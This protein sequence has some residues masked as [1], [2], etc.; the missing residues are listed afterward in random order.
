MKKLLTF[1]LCTLLLFACGGGDDG[2]GNAPSGGSEFLNV[3]NVDV[4][5]SE[6][7][8]KLSIQASA[9]CDWQVSSNDSWI[10]NIAPSSGRGSRDVSITLSG[11][12][13][14]SSSARKA[15][16]T[17]R[18]SSGT[19]TRTVTLTQAASK[20]YIEISGDATINFGNKADSRTIPIRSNT[21]WSVAVAVIT[22]SSDWIQVSPN[23]GSND[24]NVTLTVKDNNTLVEQKAKLT[25]MGTGGTT[26]E[27][28]VVQ[29]AASA[30]TLTRPQAS[31][32][33]TSEANVYFT[34]DSAIPVTSCGICYATTQ[35]TPD[36]KQD[37]LFAATATTSPVVVRMT[38]LTS[39]TT[40]FVYGY[41]ITSEGTA[42]YSEAAT[43]TTISRWPNEDDVVTPN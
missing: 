10:S 43:F 20:E 31:D 21:Q 4:A 42:Y 1:V 9:N 7:A 29:S 34:F 38:G 25:I 5:G 41:V 35:K 32:I 39:G 36:V 22:G 18:N 40:Y 33:T 15:T 24:G 12:N 37:A 8:A 14:S 11:V 27:L 30:P 28:T 3:S 13:P 19:I 6:T 17:V 23:Q 26:K 2:G 16:L